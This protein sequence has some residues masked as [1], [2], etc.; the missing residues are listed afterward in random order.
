[1]N[2]KQ[3][4]LVTYEQAKRLKE[5]EFD[6]ATREFYCSKVLCG[7]EDS[8]DAWNKQKIVDFISAPTVALAL[9]WI[10]DEKDIICHVITQMKHFR[11]DY[12]FLYRLNYAQIK[13]ERDYIDYEAAESALLDELLTILEKEK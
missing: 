12:R 8:V 5:L 3:L 7:S 10:R 2:T 9:K 6:W 4:Q 11:L 13:S 1:M